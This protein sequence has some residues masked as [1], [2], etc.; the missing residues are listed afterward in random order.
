MAGHVRALWLRRIQGLLHESA[1]QHASHGPEPCA[2][3]NQ[4]MRRTT[5]VAKTY[6]KTEHLKAAQVIFITDGMLPF[7]A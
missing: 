5:Q 2:Y 1:R 4:V 7:R 6:R 3:R